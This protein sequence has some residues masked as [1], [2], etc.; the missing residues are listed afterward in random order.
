M[1]QLENKS[2]EKYV[3]SVLLPRRASREKPLWRRRRDP[4]LFPFSPPLPPPASKAGEARSAPAVCVCGGG[5]LPFT[6]W[7][8][9]AQDG[10]AGEGAVRV[11]GTTTWHLSVG[12]R[13]L[14]R[15]SYG[16]LY[17]GGWLRCCRRLCL[18]APR[19]SSGCARGLRWLSCGLGGSARAGARRAAAWVAAAPRRPAVWSLVVDSGRW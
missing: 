1:E 3:P 18:C 7:P 6:V 16:W 12:R 10:V 15:C 11:G 14:A 19:S 2:R 13:R 8:H 9:V 17:G 5:G 4:R